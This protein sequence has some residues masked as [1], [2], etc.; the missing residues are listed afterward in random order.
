[1]N[2]AASVTAIDFIISTGDNFYSNPDGLETLDDPRLDVMFN[3]TFKRPN[4]EVPWYLILGNHDCYAPDI[5]LQTQV[6]TKYAQWNMPNTYYTKVVPLESGKSALFIYLNGCVLTAK[7]PDSDEKDDLKKYHFD[8]ASMYDGQ[9]SWLIDQLTK[10]ENDSTIAWRTV[11]IHWPFFSIGSGHQD[12]GSMKTNLL[13]DM[14]KYNVD[15]VLSGHD[16][17]MEYIVMDKNTF[18]QEGVQDQSSDIWHCHRYGIN[19][20]LGMSVTFK[21]G[22]QLHQLVAGNGGDD[23]AHLCNSYITNNE[24]VVFAQSVFGFTEV[25]ITEDEYRLRFWDI[26]SQTYKSEVIIEP[27]QEQQLIEDSSQGFLLQS[28]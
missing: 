23:T 8:A 15:V 9:K 25:Q 7:D 12:S 20:G 27:N 11:V 26:A 5:T 4:I 18:Q 13:A 16:H 3:Y 17:V 19:A 24:N 21:Q 1:M 14:V 28:S 2:K 22:E 10:Y 6:H